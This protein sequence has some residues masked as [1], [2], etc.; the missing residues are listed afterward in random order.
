MGRV[1]KLFVSCS[2]MHAN[3]DIKFTNTLATAFIAALNAR[4]QISHVSASLF[5]FVSFLM[6]PFFLSLNNNKP[7]ASLQFVHKCVLDPKSINFDQ[8]LPWVGFFSSIRIFFNIQHLSHC[9]SC[10]FFILRFIFFN[11]FEAQPFSDA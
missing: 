9:C 11:R 7:F 2:K 5:I 8:N 10:F 4:S 1:R 6:W 3:D